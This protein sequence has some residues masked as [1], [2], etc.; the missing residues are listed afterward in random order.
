M[1]TDP[2]DNGGLFIGRRPGTRPIKYRALPKIAN[3]RR[4]MLDRWLAI[5]LLVAMAFVNLLFW[6]PLPVAWMWV[7]SQVDYKTGSTFLGIIT[8]FMGLLFTLLLGL[9]ALRRLDGVWILVRRAAGVDQ[10]EG[11]LGK[12]FVV[13][14][15]IGTLVFVTWLVVFS[16]TELYPVGITF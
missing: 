2:T 15:G 9:I 5:A 6:G 10:R 4:Q 13:T 8:A 7:G 3:A 12:I 1:R 11:T 14:C 16:G